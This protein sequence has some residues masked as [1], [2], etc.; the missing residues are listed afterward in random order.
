MFST[1]PFFFQANSHLELAPHERKEENRRDPSKLPLQKAPPLTT[2][3][4]HP[5][6]KTVVFHPPTEGLSL[7]FKRQAYALMHLMPN[8]LNVSHAL[9]GFT[10]ALRQEKEPAEKLKPF[11]LLLKTHQTIQGRFNFLDRS[12]SFHNYSTH[13]LLP[14]LLSDESLSEKISEK[15][16]RKILKNVLPPKEKRDLF[17]I[18]LVP[19]QEGESEMRMHS[20]LSLWLQ[21]LEKR[22]SPAIESFICDWIASTP[23]LPAKVQGIGIDDPPFKIP[24]FFPLLEWLSL[25]PGL[26]NPR[27]ILDALIER[28]EK[29]GDSWND[30]VASTLGAFLRQ[31]LLSS[32]GTD[33]SPYIT[34]PYLE[35][36]KRKVQEIFDHWETLRLDVTKSSFQLEEESPK[37]LLILAFRLSEELG[38]PFHLTLLKKGA[39]WLDAIAQQAKLTSKHPLICMI[40]P[41]QRRGENCQILALLYREVLKRI[42]AEEMTPR[43]DLEYLMLAVLSYMQKSDQRVETPLKVEQLLSLYHSNPE[44]FNH[45]LQYQIKHGTLISPL[46]LIQS[47]SMVDSTAAEVNAFKKWIHLKIF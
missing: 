22:P 45:N 41:N 31:L 38:A 37:S 7:S 44:T 16:L 25:I 34:G 46:Q 4:C 33:A 40:D 26:K 43:G 27:N 5:F 15:D 12:A 9:A 19:G 28:A 18:S 1:L 2:V 8:T 11:L 35:L 23:L 32:Y 14:L 21:L 3:D 47:L 17:G 30:L 24:L 6:L 10:Q 39:S 13:C 42:L 36:Q 20:T 29:N